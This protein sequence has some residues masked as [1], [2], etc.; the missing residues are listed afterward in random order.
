MVRPRCPHEY[1]HQSDDDSDASPKTCIDTGTAAIQIITHESFLHKL[2]EKRTAP[3]LNG[4]LAED[5]RT[6]LKCD[7]RQ[8]A[9]TSQ[10][11]NRCA[12]FAFAS[13]RPW[14]FDDPNLLW[15]NS[16]GDISGEVVGSARI[17]GCGPPLRDSFFNRTGRLRPP[18]LHP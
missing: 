12:T 6:G 1:Q 14:C 9:L 18:R 3:D 13:N 17:E 11:R 10:C 4:S 8:A 16:F 2:P 7:A 5:E 15:R